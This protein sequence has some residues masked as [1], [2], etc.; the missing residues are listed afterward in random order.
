MD[1]E[2]QVQAQVE[3]SQDMLCGQA[4]SI[5]PSIHPFPFHPHPTSSVRESAIMSLCGVSL[6]PTTTHANV[7]SAVP[8]SQIHDR[9][10]LGLPF[11]V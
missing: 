8:H 3:P 7:W 2:T 5:H 1:V 9:T 4:S 6:F 11:D 10:H